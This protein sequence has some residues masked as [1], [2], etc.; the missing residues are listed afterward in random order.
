MIPVLLLS[1]ISTWQNFLKKTLGTFMQL[2][3]RTRRCQLKW[4]PGLGL[5]DIADYWRNL[6]ILNAISTASPHVRTYKK[7]PIQ[8]D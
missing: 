2:L 7:E 3:R 6:A 8:L 5:K 1:Q 4:T